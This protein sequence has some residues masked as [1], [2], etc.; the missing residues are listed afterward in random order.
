MNIH[1]VS[2][3]LLTLQCQVIDYLAKKGYNRTEAMLRMESASQELDNR[4]SVPPLNEEA[5]PKFALAFGSFALY[6]TVGIT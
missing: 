2:T 1:L 6:L 3:L 5:R 4:S